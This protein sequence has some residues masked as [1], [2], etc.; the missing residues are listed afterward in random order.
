MTT[1]NEATA[2][3]REA[4]TIELNLPV[5]EKI[6][7]SNGWATA[8]E[9]AEAIG[10]SERQVERIRSGKSRPG[11]DFIAGLLNAAEEAGFRRT[12]HVV[13]KSASIGKD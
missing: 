3:P 6:A 2:A 1:A 4:M 7:R 11:T 5:F 9:I 10:V 12:F 13:P 8:A